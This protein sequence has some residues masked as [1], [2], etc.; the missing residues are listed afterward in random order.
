[1]GVFIYGCFFVLPFIMLIVSLE[2]KYLNSKSN[3]AFLDEKSNFKEK[4]KSDLFLKMTLTE[5][6]IYSIMLFLNS[7]DR[8]YFY[9]F[10][11]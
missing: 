6:D 9:G 1:M 10:P 7:I 4:N 5:F 3:E 11:A 2:T 8:Y